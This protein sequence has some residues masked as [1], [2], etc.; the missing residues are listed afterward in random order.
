MRQLILA[1]VVLSV[2]T[3]LPAQWRATL[4]AG[5][6]AS[7]GDAQNASDPEQPQLR[8]DRPATLRF[9][10]SH[11]GT[12]WRVGVDLHHTSADLA[13]V[14]ATSVV[15]TLDALKAWGS[16]VEI[17]RKI[18]G[19]RDGAMLLVGVGATLDRWSFDLDNSAARWRVA[20]RGSLETDYRIGQRW[21]AV[22]RGE[23][24]AG[25]SVFTPDEIPQDFT[26][27]SA[28]RIGLLVGVTRMF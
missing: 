22:V 21:S 3:V 8:A 25:P 17:A 14:G 2:P 16:G 19:A 9:G 4:L 28:L 5:S 15:A 13:E 23:L 18:A 10:L 11:D 1:A 12:A 7:H 26:R 20:A 27:H 24:T 6:A